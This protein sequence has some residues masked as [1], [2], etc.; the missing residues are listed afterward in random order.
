M[1]K[2]EKILQN[3]KKPTDAELLLD[4]NN[5]YLIEKP[6][7]NKSSVP[8]GK[9]KIKY[10]MFNKPADETKPD[11]YPALIEDDEFVL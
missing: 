1:T 4:I 10:L 6:Q 5:E 7:V 9:Y 8:T 2:L 11:T 3:K